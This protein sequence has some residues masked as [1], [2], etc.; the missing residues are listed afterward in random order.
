MFKTI[1]GSKLADRS[2]G[3]FSQLNSLARETQ[4]IVRTSAKFS[5]EGFLLSLFKAVL[6]GKASFGQIARDLKRSEKRSISRQAVHERV[7]KTAVSFMISVTGQ[8]LKE[9][10]VEQKLICSKVF[11]RVLIEDST[12]AK[13]HVNNAGDFP[14]HGNGKGKT[15]GCKSDLVFDLLTGEPLYQTLHLATDQ[16]REL[17]KDLVDLVEKDDL[18]LRDMGYFAVKEF[19]LIA[20]RGAYWLSRV[21]VSVKICDLEGSKLETILRNSKARQLELEVLVTEDRHRARLLAVRAAPEVAKERRRK[22]RQKARE[23][24]KQ[25]SKDMLLRDGWYL[26][27]TNIGEDLMGSS[28]LFKLYATRWQIEITFRAWKQSGQLIK[29]LARDTNEFHLQCLMYAAIII[30]I[31]TMKIASL[32]HQ[33][34]AR[35]RLSLEKLADDLGSHILTLLSLDHFGQYDPDPRHIKMDPRSRKSLLQIAMECL[36]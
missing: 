31:L 13:T 7:D 33:Q 21:P 16:D 29:A 6:T 1:S 18:V 36:T 17:G 35:D 30:L 2:R 34:H 27:I 26:L 15:A 5:A 9:R 4:L 19:D 25:P 24:G 11:N 14:G 12:Q 3:L 32:L 8:A 28:D 23:L 20:H 22:R 10:W